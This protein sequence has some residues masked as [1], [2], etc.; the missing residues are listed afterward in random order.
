[1][2]GSPTVRRRKVANGESEG[3]Q[4]KG[5]T[6]SDPPISEIEPD[7]SD[8]DVGREPGNAA[9]EDAAPAD[10]L[11][12][13]R[14]GINT[15]PCSAEFWVVVGTLVLCIVG[16][17]YLENL[18]R[19]PSER[20]LTKEELA[21]RDGSNGN[22]IYLA[23]VGQVFDV[24]KGGK[25]YG[26]NGGYQFFTGKDGSRA[27]LTGDFKNDLIEDVSDFTPE[28]LKG[29]VEWRDFY[30]EFKD[31]EYVGK[32]E[33]A[34]YDSTGK[35]TRALEEVELGAIEGLKV[36]A[37]REA[38]KKE[39][40]NCNSRWSQAK[41]GEVWCEEGYPRRVLETIPGAKPSTRCACFKGIG[42][43]DA[44]QVYPDCAPDQQRCKTKKK[45]K[46]E[47]KQEENQEEKEQEEKQEEG[48]DPPQKADDV[49]TEL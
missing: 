39:H 38:A 40:P 16:V 49:N 11:A 48:E 31:Y 26:E 43:S 25:Y 13:I 12:P 47:E 14:E 9:G 46:K 32:L 10:P 29:L 20:V 41:G 21:Q 18:P 19:Q 42:F 1:M 35:P 22:P 24:T 2:S 27:Y 4:S 3:I 37:R 15:A 7:E 33:G 8:E 28:Q 17:K 34:F 6:K 5:S 44:R 36:Q 45:D 23:I 30:H